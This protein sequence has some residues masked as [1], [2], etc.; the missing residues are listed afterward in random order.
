MSNRKHV[1]NGILSC[2]L[3]LPGLALAGEVSLSGQGNVSYEPDSARLQFTASAESTLPQKATEQVTSLMGQWREAISQYRGQLNNYTDANVTLY[4]RTIPAD[5]RGDE[6]EKRSVASQT[7]KFEIDDLALL[8]PLLK[9]AQ[10]LGLD[11][12]LSPNQF[13]HSDEASLQREA[14][15]NAIAEAKAKCKFVASQLDQTCGDVVSINVNSGS[16]P[17]PMMMASAKREGAIV[18]NVGE[19]EIKATVNATFELD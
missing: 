2:A 3:L 1:I 13:F 5:K 12:R 14:L 8:N 9:Q 15:A 17:M 10:A 11:Y 6:P 4:S 7:V 16:R 19:Q 18:S